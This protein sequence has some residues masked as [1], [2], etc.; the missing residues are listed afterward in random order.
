MLRFRPWCLVLA[1]VAMIG[2]NVTGQEAD[3]FAGKDPLRQRIARS[4][5]DPVTLTFRV[6]DQQGS[7]VAG[8]RIRGPGIFRPLHTDESGTAVWQTGAG[9]LR[10][11]ATRSSG[12]LRFHAGPPPDAVM[13]EVSEQVSLATLIGSKSIEF[14][15]VPGVRLSGRVIGQRDKQPVAG[16]TVTL[17]PDDASVDAP[18]RSSTTDERG[19]WSIVVPRVATTITLSGYVDGYKLQDAS[20]PPAEQTR[21][22]E[23]PKDLSLI[24]ISEPTRH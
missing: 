12:S 11:W 1:G 3:P 15:T 4:H 22:V 20:N 8:T 21:V 19:M 10:K 16:V 18:R 9:E 24:H 7:P 17:Q 5:A 2:T 14:R 13:P 23:I 6:L